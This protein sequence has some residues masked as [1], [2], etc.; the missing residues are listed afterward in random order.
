MMSANPAIRYTGEVVYIYAFDVAY[1]TARKPIRELLGQPV[2]QFSVDASKRSPRQL[3][4]YRPQMVRLPPMERIGPLGPVRVQRVIKLLPVGAI[5]ISVRVPF[6][7]N[8]FEELVAFHD[9]QFSNGS[10][11]DE[12]RRLAQEVTAELRGHLIRPQPQLPDEEAYTVF[13]VA[14]PLRDENSQPMDAEQWFHAH[15]PQ[16]A[17]LL[18]QEEEMGRLSTQEAEE[19]TG[20][21]LSYYDNDLVVVDWDAALLVD[22]PQDFDETLYIMELA[23]LQLAELEAYDRLL[24]DALERSYRDLGERPLRSRSHILHEL[25][26]IRIDMARFNDELSN[27]SK[28]F[29]D[30]H[31]ARI[32]ERISLRFHLADWHRT[33]DGKLKTLD[34]LYQILKHD[35][36]HRVMLWL[37]IAIVLLF[38][39]DLIILML[40]FK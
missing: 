5:S 7:V 18:T 14:A 17:A 9:L 11:H 29:G 40:Q 37:E 10:V 20:Q 16:V 34:D 32:Y 24:D 19:S 39:T 6:A 30:W 25:R 3:F 8:H 22:E 21:Y 26:E 15:R 2:A 23:N 38:V 35:Q 28:F 31:L 33:I 4:F 27:S 12:V 1:D 13:C 36:N